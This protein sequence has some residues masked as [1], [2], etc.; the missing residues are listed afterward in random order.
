MRSVTKPVLSVIV[1]TRDR[2]AS[3][4]K[5][6]ASLASA[7]E[8]SAGAA[9]ILIV[10]NGSGDATPQALAQWCDQHPQRRTLRVEAPGKARAVNAALAWA[11][12]DL[13]AFT[14]DDVEVCPDWIGAVIAFF[15]EHVEYAAAMGRTL[16]PPRVTDAALLALIPRYPG[17]IPVFDGGEQVRDLDDLFGCNM[18]MRRSLLDHVGF[19][20][21]KLGPGASGLSEDADLARRIL[22]SGLRI[23]YM[24]DA[25]VY[26][27]VDPARLTAAYYR[28][29]QKRLGR[30]EYAA[31]PEWTV[32]RALRR[33]MEGVLAASWWGVLGRVE[34]RTRAWERAR[35]H[36]DAAGWLWR[37]PQRSESGSDA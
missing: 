34:R 29:F 22:R 25:V 11:D 24:P 16:P 28:E 9:Q 15:E 2:E 30:S 33:T 31:H 5:T 26:H 32:W 10:D 17:A 23:G 21:E 36:A 20:N 6:L 4:H 13:V 35:R 7:Q 19:F 3:L 8:R 14:D 1:A 12:T 37:H 18:A 27:E